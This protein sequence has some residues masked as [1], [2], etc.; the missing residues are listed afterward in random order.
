MVC[1]M[2]QIL[3][4]CLWSDVLAMMF[5]LRRTSTSEPSVAAQTFC[6]LR[7][8]CFGDCFVVSLCLFQLAIHCK[9]FCCRNPSGYPVLVAPRWLVLHPVVVDQLVSVPVD[10]C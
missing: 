10:V 8:L 7:H 5:S 4:P 6:L 9:L 2:G 3:S 1:E